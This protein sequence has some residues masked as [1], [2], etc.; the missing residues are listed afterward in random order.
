METWGLYREVRDRV[1]LR[2]SRQPWKA[3]LRRRAQP[4]SALYLKKKLRERMIRE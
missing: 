3:G 1:K 4:P 2:I